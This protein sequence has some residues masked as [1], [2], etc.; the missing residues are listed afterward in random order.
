MAEEKK[1]T[2]K[3]RGK[4]VEVSEEVYR[5]YIQPIRTEQRRKR[6]EWKCNLIHKHHYYRCDKKCEECPYFLAGQNAVGNKLSL[7]L[8]A[9]NGIDIVDTEM[10]VEEKHIEEETKNEELKKLYIAIS[11]LTDKEQEFIKMVYFEE[12][13]TIEIGKMFGISHQA[14]SKIKKKILKKLK[15]FF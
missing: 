7:D 1:Y 4:N 3:V 6:R 12:K 11:Q 10:D 5:A 2:I 13:T 9:D 8:M 14:V 15:L